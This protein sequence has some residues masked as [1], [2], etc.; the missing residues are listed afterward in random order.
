MVSRRS[1]L[2]LQLALLLPLVVGGLLGCRSLPD[3]FREPVRIEST[4]P[5]AAVFVDGEPRGVTPL[6]LDLTRE[7]SYLV[8]LEKEGYRPAF[9]YLLPEVSGAQ[10]FVRFGP[11]VE[12]GA[13]A[14]LSPNPLRVELSPHLVPGSIGAQ[15][16]DEFSYRVLQADALLATGRLTPEEHTYIIGL[17]IDFF[18]PLTPPA[19]SP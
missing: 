14:Q 4:P 16:F 10:P 8:R 9:D 7:R 11:L 19:E 5:G 3:R 6:R 2:L 17:L 12:A 18:G 15:P 1:L 13:Y